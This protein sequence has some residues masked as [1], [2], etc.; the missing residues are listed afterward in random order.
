MLTFRVAHFASF[1]NPHKTEWYLGIDAQTAPHIGCAAPSQ[2]SKS[3]A[4]GL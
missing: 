1:A 2:G 4:G 3:G